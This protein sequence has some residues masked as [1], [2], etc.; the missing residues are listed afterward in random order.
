MSVRARLKGIFQKFDRER[1]LIERRA[2]MLPIYL[3]IKVR[4][5]KPILR[6]GPDTQT[7]APRQARLST[8]GLH[9]FMRPVLRE[10]AKKE[11]V[12][13]LRLNFDK[14]LALAKF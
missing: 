12:N 5:R 7:R 2:K 4:I 1:F 8:L 3:L 9:G 11:M 14:S 13:F 6:Y 10:R